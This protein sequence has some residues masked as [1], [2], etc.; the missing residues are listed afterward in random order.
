MQAPRSSL[1]SQDS[2]SGIFITLSKLPDHQDT[3]ILPVIAQGEAA[4]LLE[5]TQAK[6]RLGPVLEHNRVAQSQIDGQLLLIRGV[7]AVLLRNINSSVPTLREVASYT[8]DAQSR[9]S[10]IQ[11]LV[12]KQEQI[13]AMINTLI[14]KKRA[15]PRN[16]SQTSTH[17]MRTSFTK[18]SKYATRSSSS[19]TRD[20]KE[21]GRP[22]FARTQGPL[23]FGQKDR[24][25]VVFDDGD[26]GDGSPQEVSESSSGRKP[27]V[28]PSD[29][30]AA[31]HL[32]RHNKTSGKPEAFERPFS[33]APR[34]NEL[35]TEYGK[36]VSMEMNRLGSR[37]NCP[38][39]I[40]R[41]EGT[42]PATACS[43]MRLQYQIDHLF[44][45]TGHAKPKLPTES[46][47]DWYNGTQVLA[48][49]VEDYAP[50][51]TD[52][53]TTGNTGNKRCWSDY[54]SP[55]GGLKRP[56]V[57]LASSPAPPATAEINPHCDKCGRSNHDTSQCRA[58]FCSQC[59]SHHFDKD[60]PMKGNSS[61]S[62]R[63][64]R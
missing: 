52:Q 23:R 16:D 22:N 60:C 41:L 55:A 30:F 9:L 8:T 40:T 59:K 1:C 63:R 53:S 58:P 18:A 4:T 47:L 24:K 5:L 12:A 27:V 3:P 13:L 31:I 14:Q 37:N 26:P 39:F 10:E 38:G 61:R 43:L 62:S 64:S 42:V 57:S 11:V 51:S 19:N 34:S 50:S 32:N 54:A 56:R 25:H 2:K 6:E 15:A 20:P 45:V 7:D 46:F 21:H 33:M 49:C 44:T 29:E 17:N 36:R 35:F 28:P 48:G